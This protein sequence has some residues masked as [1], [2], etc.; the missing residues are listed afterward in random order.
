MKTFI[1][2]VDF[3]DAS[4][5][6]ALFAAEL[7]KRWEAIVV[8]YNAFY[9][10]IPSSEA[11]ALTPRLETIFSEDNAQ[12]E[13]KGKEIASRYNISVECFSSPLSIVD[14]LPVLVRK[15]QADLVIMGMRGINSF[16]RKLF[17]STTV[18]IL[19]I[20]KFP[21]LV[22]PEE[23]KFLEMKN[24]IFAYQPGSISKNNDLKLLQGLAELFKAKVKILHVSLWGEENKDTPKKE[25]SDKIDTLLLNIRHEYVQIAEGDFLKGINK[26]IAESNAQLLVM[27]PGERNF[28]ESLTNKSNTRKAALQTHIPLLALPNP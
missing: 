14:Q 7:A 9:F 24:I 27:V 5:N 19:R 15:Y 16:N 22:I 10:S 6:A 13:E 25:D 8:L 21:V 18:S 3:S 28:W 20:A 4:E 26:G 1:V 23:V 11:P 12:L 17:G 2:P